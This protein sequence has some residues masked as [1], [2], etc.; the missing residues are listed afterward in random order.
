MESDALEHTLGRL[1]GDHAITFAQVAAH[2]EPLLPVPCAVEAATL[3]EEHEVDRFHV[4]ESFRLG[5][6]A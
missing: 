3:M 1:A 4:R 5:R 6:D 2:V